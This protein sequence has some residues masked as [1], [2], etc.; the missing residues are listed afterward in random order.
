MSRPL[1]KYT[2]IATSYD[3]E[4]MQQKQCSILVGDTITFAGDYEG[5]FDTLRRAI[6]HTLPVPF[7][8]GLAVGTVLG[9]LGLVA[10]VLGYHQDIFARFL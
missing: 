5:R 8:I 4:Y 9:A 2:V 10:F 1:K 6:R 3:P 7:W